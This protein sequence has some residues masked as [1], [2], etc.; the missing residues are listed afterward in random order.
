MSTEAPFSVT[1]K[2]G[3]RD[4]LLVTLRGDTYAE[5]V[6]NA[7]QV[8]GDPVAAETFIKEVYG[9]ALQTPMS[10]AVATVAKTLGPV[11]TIGQP[12]PVPGHA[13]PSEPVTAA[14]W[15]VAPAPPAA[16]TAPATAPVAGPPVE[17]PGDCVHGQ[18]VYR[19]SMARG[20][21]WRRW[22]CAVEWQKGNDASNTARCRAVNV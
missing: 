7:T 17:Y 4:G 21:P 10:A 1:G 18:R 5:L 9:Q 8:I 14:P 20:R 3:G 15:Q 19:D 12:L 16:A 11:S 6:A 13:A 2:A 22:E